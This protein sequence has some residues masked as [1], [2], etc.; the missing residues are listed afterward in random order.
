MKGTK[1]PG[2]SNT[3]GIAFARLGSEGNETNIKHIAPTYFDS[4]SVVLCFDFACARGDSD[5]ESDSDCNPG[6]RN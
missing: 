5:H 1:D 6:A 3:F 2:C 4:W